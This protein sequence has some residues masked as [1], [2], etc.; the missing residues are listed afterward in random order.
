M[1]IPIHDTTEF[2]KILSPIANKSKIVYGDGAYDSLKER[3]TSTFSIAGELMQLFHQ[4]K[5]EFFNII[6]RFSI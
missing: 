4:G 6:K 5:G 2:R 1:S 3:A